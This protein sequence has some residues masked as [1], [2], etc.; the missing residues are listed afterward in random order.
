VRRWLVLPLLALVGLLFA[1]PGAAAVRA[2][3][4]KVSIAVADGQY[5]LNVENTGDSMIT[6]FT[7]VPASTLKVTSVVS[8]TVGTCQASGAGFS[9]SVSLKPP[10]C[11]CRSGDAMSV[12]FAG[13]GESSGSSI[14]IGSVTVAASGGGAVAAPPPPP[15]PPT[16]TPPPAKPPKAKPLCK[17]GQKSTATKRCRK[18]K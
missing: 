4:A 13:Y 8:S 18:R 2:D 15:P 11:A 1:L 10:A 3:N 14:Q 9:C 7:F 16:T 12:A 5:Q 6:S 17:R